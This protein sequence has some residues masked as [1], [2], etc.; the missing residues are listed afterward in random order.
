[1]IA[2][3]VE[4]H[5]E[6]GIRLQGSVARGNERADSDIDLTV[7]VPGDALLRDNELLSNSN[8]WSMR[9]LHDETTGATLNINWVGADELLE[10]VKHTGAAAWYM[11]LKGS[12]LRDPAGVIAVCEAAIAGWFQ[13]NPVILAAWNRQQ[14]AVEA[15][16]KELAPALEFPTQPAFL[17]HL[18]STMLLGQPRGNN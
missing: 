7:V 13:A 2:R 12:T 10:L 4:A 3:C 5:P 15:F 14:A 16:K 18:E 6:C 9:L 1:M 11:F 8:H 17:R